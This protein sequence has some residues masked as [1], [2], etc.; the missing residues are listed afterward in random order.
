MGR[1]VGGFGLWSPHRQPDSI[2]IRIKVSER[3][4][5]GKDEKAAAEI[6]WSFV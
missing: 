2:V 4:V 6:D 1:L 5:Y 3:L